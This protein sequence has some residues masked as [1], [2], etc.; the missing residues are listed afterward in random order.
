MPFGIK[1]IP[2]GNLTRVDPHEAAEELLNFEDELYQDSAS[3]RRKKN[4]DYFENEAENA[5][6]SDDEEDIPIPKT[7]KR[8]VSENMN[9][10]TILEIESKK[11]SK[12]KKMKKSSLNK[13]SKKLNV[14][15]L[16]PKKKVKKSSKKFNNTFTE[17]AIETKSN[18]ASPAEPSTSLN[19]SV[20]EN[21]SP[22]TSATPKKSVVSKK[23]PQKNKTSPG[24]KSVDSSPANASMP[25]LT[26]V[27][28][29]LEE[30]NKVNYLAWTP[31]PF[32]KKVLINMFYL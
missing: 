19:W 13:K 20:D 23:T 8:K 25:W 16:L 26:P 7:K 3:R 2:L 5:I 4:G 22:S 6:S 1:E 17:N 30:Q 12:E 32:I 11:E 15:E 28:T 29:R 24:K 31:K 21:T 27:L 18:V 14:S 9:G 10:G